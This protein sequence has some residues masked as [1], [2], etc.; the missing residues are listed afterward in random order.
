[1]MIAIRVVELELAR[2][3]EQRFSA[4]RYRSDFLRCLLRLAPA[5][6]PKLGPFFAGV[7]AGDHPCPERP[8]FPNWIPTL[9][10][11]RLG[12]PKGIKSCRVWEYPQRL[13]SL[14]HQ[15]ER[16]SPRI[17]RFTNFEIRG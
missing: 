9:G 5:F 8:F 7:A 12:G 2:F 6:L 16:R 10:R 15:K 3:T 4:L 1:V 11:A 14:L 13:V 17:N